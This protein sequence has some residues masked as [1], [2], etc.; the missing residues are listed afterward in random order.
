MELG[1]N[2]CHTNK[3]MHPDFIIKKSPKTPKG[4]SKAANRRTENDK[5]KRTKKQ[6]TIYKTSHRKLKIEQHE[7]HQNL[8]VNSGAPNGLNVIG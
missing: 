8:Q 7:P 5:R 1:K 3:N 4:Q 6:T 2:Y